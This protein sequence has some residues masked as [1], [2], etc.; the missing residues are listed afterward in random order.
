MARRF[1]SA[2]K[3]LT[4]ST[5][6]AGTVG[7]TFFDT[8]SKTIQVHDGSAWV[9]STVRPTDGAA[10]GR[11]FTGD[12]SPTS[13]VVGDLWVDGDT[14]S[15]ANGSFVRWQIFATAG[16]TTLSGND[17]NGI[18]LSYVVGYEQVYI[19]GALQYRGQDYTA[20]TGT[21]VTGISAL[22]DGDVVEVLV[23]T[24]I[25][26]PA[27]T[28]YSSTAPASPAVGQ[29]WVDTSQAVN[30]TASYVIAA[31]TP[32]SGF[33]NAII[34]GDFRINQRGFTSV[35]TSGT[36]GFDRWKIF[37]AGGTVTYTPQPFT[38]GSPAQAG[39]E[40]NNFARLVSTGQSASS[41][42][43]VIQQPIEGV[44]TFAN[45]TVTVSFWAKAS[46]GT[47]KVAVELAQIFG[48]GGSPSADV[49]VLGGQVTLSTSWARY[50]VQITLPTIAG[51]T[52][53]TND[54][55]NVNLWTSGGTNYNGRLNSLGIQNNTFDF[56]GVQV[57][58]GTTAT[59]FEQRP[60]GTELSLCQRYFCSSFPIG[61]APANNLGVSST[62]SGNVL[63]N[64]STTV[65]NSYA[66][67]KQFPVPM[68]SSPTM[69]IYSPSNNPGTWET[70][71]S[72]SL[73]ANSVPVVDKNTLGFLTY[74]SGP[75]V[76]VTNGAWAA[77]AEL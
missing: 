45:S 18:A 48:A 40:S 29:L 5:P 11:V 57:E 60:I 44:R 36:Y 30:D 35:T 70:Y 68:R 26:L 3:L 63:S 51:K 38:L 55:L 12:T 9:N 59:P 71:N 27:Y 13:P 37:N 39:Y 25:I 65:S 72:S 46:S 64:Y 20:T 66:T 4:G 50:S 74:F 62:T 19:N 41:D 49:N 10:G 24:S 75:T 42:Y 34:N 43:A 77:S 69:T 32:I 54:A 17:V 21:T 56:W 73:L 6:P 47:P 52:I 22:L 23:L 14:K 61:I 76:T 16:Q 67:F 53:T 8:D 33:R 28:S 2:I 58:P 31:T 15:A 1:L 7:D